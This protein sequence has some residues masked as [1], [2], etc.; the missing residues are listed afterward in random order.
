MKN[1]INRLNVSP[2]TLFSLAIIIVVVFY[3][4]AYNS[5]V[6]FGAEIE[7]TPEMFC[8]VEKGD[9]LWE[10]SSIYAPNTNK[11]YWIDQVKAINHIE[12]QYIYPGQKLY[13]PDIK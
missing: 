2:I 13:I 7:K 5:K 1:I 4:N 8:I 9:T 3:I 10:L 12:S 11:N 6:V